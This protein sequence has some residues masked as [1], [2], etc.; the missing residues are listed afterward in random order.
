MKKI[1]EIV[2]GGITGTGERISYP[3]DVFGETNAT[4]EIFNGA[5]ITPASQQPN[6]GDAAP[7]AAWPD[8]TFKPHFDASPTPPHGHG[9]DSD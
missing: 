3:V 4:D 6:R 8:S 9:P 7:S 5:G 2:V 1:K